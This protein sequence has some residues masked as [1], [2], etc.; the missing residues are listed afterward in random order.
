MI[1]RFGHGVATFIV[2]FDCL[3]VLLFG[4]CDKNHSLMAD[5]MLLRFG[6]FLRMHVLR[7]FFQSAKV[8]ILSHPS[9]SGTVLGKE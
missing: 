4:G 8:I 7:I 5:T 2:N 9:S 1:R 3:E 6:E